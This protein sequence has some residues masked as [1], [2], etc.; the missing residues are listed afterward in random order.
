MYFTFIFPL[1]IGLITIISFLSSFIAKIEKKIKGDSG[2]DPSEIRLDI[3]IK[4]K[5]KSKWK[6]IMMKEMSKYE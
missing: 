6:P 2:V 5:L 3:F 1:V 4:I